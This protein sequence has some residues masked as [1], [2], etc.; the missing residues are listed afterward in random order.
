MSIQNKAK[1]DSISG[2]K[3]GRPKKASMSDEISK[4]DKKRKNQQLLI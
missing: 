2:K 4:Q 3:R 1:A